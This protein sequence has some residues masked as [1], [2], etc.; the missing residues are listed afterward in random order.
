MIEEQSTSIRD[1][2]QATE[3]IVSVTEEV[4]IAMLEQKTGVDEFSITMN[5][6][7]DLFLES[8][9]SIDTHLESL[10]KLI[11]F[12]EQTDGIV[13]EN[14]RVFEELDTLLANFDIKQNDVSEETS[15]KLVE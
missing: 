12:I 4:K 14:S 2:L 3:S 8:K 9:A 5:S 6:L 7:K 15:I 10:S 13:R 1:I 11:G